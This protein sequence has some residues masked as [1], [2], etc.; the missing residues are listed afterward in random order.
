MDPTGVEQDIVATEIRPR[1]APGFEVLQ[2]LISVR[3]RGVADPDCRLHLHWLFDMVTALGLLQK[4]VGE[5]GEVDFGEYLIE[6]SAYWRRVLDGRPIDIVVSAGGSRLGGDRASILALIAHELIANAVD[7][8]FSS[9]GAGRL[10]LAIA[11]LPGGWREFVVGD[12]GLSSPEAIAE[13]ERDGLALVRS[14]A[15]TL[16]G[17]F[18][19]SG[20]PGGV[21]ARLRFPA[22]AGPSTH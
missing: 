3:L 1:L 5:G 2:T 11:E 12:T 21:I 8:A 15:E 16:G 18:S 17:R 20:G 7:H 6:T 9:E 14:L 22:K 10:H 19:L 4:R 13:R